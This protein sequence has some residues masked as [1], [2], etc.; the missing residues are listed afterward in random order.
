[1]DQAEYDR[2]F[3]KQGI[4]VGAEPAPEDAE[5]SQSIVV[6]GQS[7]APL[8]LRVIDSTPQ[9][10]H[11]KEMSR[12]QEQVEVVGH[13]E[14]GVDIIRRRGGADYGGNDG[15]RQLMYRFGRLR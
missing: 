10:R 9:Q 3:R 5:Q 8:R 14:G 7:A 4:I 11:E 6:D 12:L 15:W 13:I 2:Q 1:V